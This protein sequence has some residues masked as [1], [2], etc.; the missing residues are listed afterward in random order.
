M[1]QPSPN[2][3]NGKDAKGRFAK[4]NA[5]G[6]GNP[7]AKQVGQLRSA[8]LNAVSEEDIA[9][10]IATLVDLA[11]GGDVQAAKL[12]LERTLGRPTEADLIER[13]EQLEAV[14]AEGATA[15]R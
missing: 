13:L 10:I 14:A 15:W 6:P 7:H 9:R 8:M 4:G 11:K 12:V 5:G 3:S 2:G 1:K